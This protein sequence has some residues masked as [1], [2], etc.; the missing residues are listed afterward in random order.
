LGDGVV[1]MGPT[2]LESPQAARVSAHS[3][4]TITFTD[5]ALDLIESPA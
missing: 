3:M 1:W 4:A 5:I 2:I